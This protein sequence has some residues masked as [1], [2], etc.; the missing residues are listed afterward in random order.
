MTRT[1]PGSN[2]NTYSK[3]TESDFEYGLDI[4]AF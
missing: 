2:L 1:D 4:S 3:P